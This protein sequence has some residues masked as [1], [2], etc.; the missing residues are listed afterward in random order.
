[1][2]LMGTRTLDDEPADPEVAETE[3]LEA[4]ETDPLLPVRPTVC[5]YEDGPID[6]AIESCE[7]WAA[8]N[9][10]AETVES[11]GPCFE[12]LGM[13]GEL[14]EDSR[15]CLFPH[16]EVRFFEP[17]EIDVGSEGWG[18]PG[19]E[20]VVEGVVCAV[21]SEEDGFEITTSLG[22]TCYRLGETE[23]APGQLSCFDGRRYSDEI[24]SEDAWGCLGSLPGR[25]A[26]SSDDLSHLTISLEGGP[27]DQWVG[28]TCRP[29][30]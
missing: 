13:S 21:Y 27:D 5:G 23:E 30:S 6:G 29:P 14:S 20:V 9:C 1:M 10:W 17:V 2:M 18:M 8:G 11:A 3:E 22:T 25:Y 24:S 7:S 16:G 12:R 19:F 15:R 4:P 26:I 28:Y